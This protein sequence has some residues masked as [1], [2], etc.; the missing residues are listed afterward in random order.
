MRLSVFL[1]RN[2]NNN[3]VSWAHQFGLH[4]TYAKQH[5][6]YMPHIRI[7][8]IRGYH[9]IRFLEQCKLKTDK[10]HEFHE[11]SLSNSIHV[12]HRLVTL[13]KMLKLIQQGWY[14]I[15]EVIFLLSSLRV[16]HPSYNQ[17]LFLYYLYPQCSFHLYSF[18][19]WTVYSEFEI[20]PVLLFIIDIMFTVE[21]KGEQ[22]Y[23]KCLLILCAT[24][25]RIK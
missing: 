15:E 9:H 1:T 17:F 20:P 2:S 5:Y 16:K 19:V 11:F 18:L 12:C 7:P 24:E 13:W 14:C 23:E 3:I 25:N 21:E 6:Y 4:I 22:N 8:Q 10:I